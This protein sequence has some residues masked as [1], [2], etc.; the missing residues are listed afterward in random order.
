MILNRSHILEVS[1]ADRPL[2]TRFLPLLAALML[3]APLVGGTVHAH[4]STA[5]HDH[6]EEHGDAGHGHD[7]HEDHAGDHDHR[8]D[9]AHA[10]E[11]N[12]M[13]IL[14]PWMNATSGRE[15]LIFLEME[16]IGDAP[17]TLTG[18][19]VPFAEEATLVG[20]A[21]QNGEGTYQPLPF[22]PV[23]PGRELELAP[24]GLAIRATGLTATFEQ[25][26][27]ARITLQTS[28]G[29]LDLTVAVEAADARQHSHAGH[30]H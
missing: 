16:N 27:T 17:V 2:F 5:D 11:G 18:A 25:G 21:L 6:E 3:T 10:F 12:G 9:A 8:K 4:E 28:A 30:A 26:D 24:E 29:A 19:D 1:M 22:V 20:F 14:H 7:D 23:Q 13:R 15:A